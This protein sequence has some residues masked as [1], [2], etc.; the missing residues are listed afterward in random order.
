MSEATKVQEDAL[1]HF[2][3]FADDQWEALKP[4]STDHAEDYQ[5]PDAAFGAVD[6]GTADLE[7]EFKLMTPEEFEKEVGETLDRSKDPGPGVMD[8]LSPS[9]ADAI[10]TYQNWQ[11]LASPLTAIPGGIEELFA[12]EQEESWFHYYA[13]RGPDEAKLIDPQDSKPT[14]APWAHSAITS[15]EDAVGNRLYEVDEVRTEIAY[16]VPI[17]CAAAEDYVGV[18][19]SNSVDLDKFDDV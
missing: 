9:G 5:P 16:L 11:F 10:G 8:V 19:L 12:D 14:D 1:K 17:L 3:T 18:D 13:A 15:W 7:Y 2:A 6:E 4:W